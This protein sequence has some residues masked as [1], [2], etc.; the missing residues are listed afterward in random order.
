MAMKRGLRFWTSITLVLLVGA[1]VAL[2]TLNLSRVAA[3]WLSGA[4][5]DTLG[6]KVTINGPV[7]LGIWPGGIKLVAQD[8]RLANA[9]WGS[10]PDMVVAGRVEVRSPV[11]ALFRGHFVVEELSIDHAEVLLETD[12]SGL[13]N[14]PRPGRLTLQD[15]VLTHIA[16]EGPHHVR[17]K[18]IHLVYQGPDG[19]RHFETTIERA[20]LRPV[21]EGLKIELLGDYRGT[22]VAIDGTVEEPMA[23]IRGTRTRVELA[24]AMG[25][26]T[27]LIAGGLGSP[28]R[29]PGFDLRLDGKAADLRDIA[30]LL[31]VRT[32]QAG[33]AVNFTANLK[34]SNDLIDVEEFSATIGGGNL[35][36]EAH[37]RFD[38]DGL[39][40]LE[41]VFA[42]EHLDLSK[43]GLGL[44]VLAPFTQLGDLDAPWPLDWLR[45]VR[46]DIAYQAEELDYRALE[47]TDVDFRLLLS[48]GVL[49]AYPVS[50]RIEGTPA[51]LE[52]AAD[53]SLD[54]PKFE[55]RAAIPE[56]GID[57]AI[58]HSGFKP[59]IGGTLD[60]AAEVRGR[61]VTPAAT[62]ASLEGNAAL[63]LADGFLEPG[64]LTKL[65]EDWRAPLKEQGEGAERA[66]LRCAKTQ[67]VFGNGYATSKMVYADSDTAVLGGAGTLDLSSGDV[68]AFFVP[69]PKASANRKA[70]KSY[71][72]D[73]PLDAMTF[74]TASPNA[75]AVP[76]ASPGASCKAAFA[77][78]VVLRLHDPTLIDAKTYEGLR[79]HGEDM[80]NYTVNQ[81]EL[82]AYRRQHPELAKQVPDKRAAGD[83]E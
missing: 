55:L 45:H 6:R 2:F 39:A 66:G 57:R 9:S 59:L 83:D 46:F 62:F 27:V 11:T 43:T 20:E 54:T 40:S 10:Q 48:D 12:Y 79:L 69:S 68:D 50:A 35:V 3:P 1:C 26:T 49:T 41:A 5:S 29:G 13:T 22:L 4:I 16:L 21:L 28:W 61:G 38:T 36:G 65:P 77:G 18:N 52:L 37:A 58:A 42:S 56:L 74:K 34:M 25:N 47:M 51:D 72:A 44:A 24:T 23:L 31:G 30:W 70:A 33:R 71:I 8:V 7:R 75:R 64:Y 15:R 80:S 76:R 19:I 63:A 32:A 73:G 67:L 17:L 78:G 14:R 82:E 60:L 53:F 81:A